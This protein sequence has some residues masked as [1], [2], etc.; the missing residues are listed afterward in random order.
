MKEKQFYMIEKDIAEMVTSLYL[1]P[2]LPNYP[3]HN[4][5]HTERVVSHVKEM[6][7]YYLLPET[8]DFILTMSAWF[9]DIGHLYGDIKDHEERGVAIMQ[10][11]LPDI[12]GDLKDAISRC[13]LATKF[14]NHPVSLHEQIICD[15]DTYHLGTPLFRETDPL[16][17]KEMEMRTGKLFPD[18]R[19]KSLQFLQEHTFFT[20]YCRRLLDQGKKENIAWLT[21]QIN[22]L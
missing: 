21:T 7:A 10:Q 18:W 20:E 11:C 1:S 14:P 15:A 22:P 2:K 8:G 19:R 4:L 13:I 17:Q 12:S 16:V 5:A 9:H 6:I 3:Y